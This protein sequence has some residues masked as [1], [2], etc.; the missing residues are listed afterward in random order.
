MEPLPLTRQGYATK[1]AERD[2]L[3]HELP[4]LLA[5]L[6]AARDLG[7]V[8]ENGELDATRERLAQVRARLAT[9]TAD[10][11]WARPVTA[12][13]DGQPSAVVIGATVTIRDERDGQ[14]SQRHVV[15]QEEA[16]PL[17]GR[18][19]TAS[20]LG[21]ALLGRPVGAVIDVS[22]PA[23]PR[24]LTILAI[25]HQAATPAAPLPA[26]APTRPDVEEATR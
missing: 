23:G 9:L 16:A 22:T 6:R 24:R 15:A 20:S 4:G 1:Q 12:P 8:S 5:R 19:S 13:T 18:V 2:A 11:E 14:V 10:L 3:G 25:H 7:D 21:S 26:T 17:D